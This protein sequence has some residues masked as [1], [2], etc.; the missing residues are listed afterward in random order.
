MRETYHIR[1][2]GVYLD[3]IGMD[4]EAWAVAKRWTP[5]PAYGYGDMAYTR[6]TVDERA[7]AQGYAWHHAVSV[8]PR[9]VTYA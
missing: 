8:V 3:L 1:H 6:R 4:A 5:A 7:R 9:G 2:D